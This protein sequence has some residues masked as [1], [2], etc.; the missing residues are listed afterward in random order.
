M[1]NITSLLT[2]LIL[3]FFITS[4]SFAGNLSITTGISSSAD[5]SKKLVTPTGSSTSTALKDIVWP[6]TNG[7]TGTNAPLPNQQGIA[8]SSVTLSNLGATTTSMTN[9]S[10]YPFMSANAHAG[11]VIDTTHFSYP[12]GKATFFQWWTSS[13]SSLTPQ[14]ASAAGRLVVEF[15]ANTTNMEVIFRGI[16]SGAL[17]VQIDGVTVFDEYDSGAASST[18]QAGAATTITLAAGSSATNNYYNQQYIY[19][20]GGTGSGQRK[21]ITAYNGTTKVATVDSAWSVNPDN[22]TT[23]ILSASPTHYMVGVSGSNY[24]PK[25]TFSGEMRPHFVRIISN[26]ALV[27]I[28]VDQAGTITKAQSMPKMKLIVLGDSIAQGTSSGSASMGDIFAQR[29]ANNLGMQLDNVSVGGIGIVANN[30]GAALTYAQRS[31][32]DVNSWTVFLA[33][34]NAGTYTLTQGATTTGSIAYNASVSTV[35]TALNTAFGSGQFYVTGAGQAGQN[36]FNIIANGVNTLGVTTEMTI[37]GAGLTLPQG[38]SASVTR[39]TGDIDK[40]LPISKTGQNLPFVLLVHGSSNDDANTATLLAAAQ[41][42]FQGLSAKYPQA[43][44]IVMGRPMTSGPMSGNALTNQTIL[45]AA[46]T[47]YLPT[48]NGQVAFLQTFDPTTGVGYLNGTTNVSTAS[49]AAGVNTDICVGPDGTHPTG[50][51]HFLLG[52][53]ASQLANQLLQG[54]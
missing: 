11:G 33:N 14:Q 35:Q 23:Y 18:A 25:F 28:N 34:A 43:K 6:I 21:R 54:P 2:I 19:T 44:I 39:Y 4:I 10:N 9:P 17:T 49:G 38:G 37:N 7:G 12:A 53:A 45:K 22:T 51:G 3:S 15:V 52:D 29:L 1:K 8:S 24:Y 41:A 32:P 48:I 50:F 30:G 20:V 5:I 40:I 27:G 31:I 47:N 42:L 13:I 26:T 16:G 36:S 46:A